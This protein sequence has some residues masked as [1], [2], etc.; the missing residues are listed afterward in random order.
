MYTVYGVVAQSNR[1]NDKLALAGHDAGSAGNK[2]QI[3]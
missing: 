1:I 2:A 3:E